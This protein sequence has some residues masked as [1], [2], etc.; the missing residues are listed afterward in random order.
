MSHAE[1]IRALCMEEAAR[2]LRAF[3]LTGLPDLERQAFDR[4]R[5]AGIDP[6]DHGTDRR[7]LE[8][9]LMELQVRQEE[10]RRKVP[11]GHF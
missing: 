1:E 5:T 3:L 6:A 9:L 11:S 10:A 8:R 2:K 4:L 7:G